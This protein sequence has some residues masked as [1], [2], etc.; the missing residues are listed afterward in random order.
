MNEAIR[1]SIEKGGLNPGLSWLTDE[2]LYLT[3]SFWQALGRALGWKTQFALSSFETDGTQ[4][5]YGLRYN[6]GVDKSNDRLIPAWLYHWHCFIDWIADG[7][8]P[9]SFFEE[10]IKNQ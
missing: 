9:D 3:P 5:E 8:T 1:K 6:G 4:D 10:L 2:Q 7:K